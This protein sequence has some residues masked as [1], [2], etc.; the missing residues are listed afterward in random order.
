M[1]Q[2]IVEDR[3]DENLGV[4]VRLLRQRCGMSIRQ[5]AERAGVTPGIISCMERGKNSPSI[6]TLSKVLAALDSDLQAF[7]GGNGD[8][9]QGPA[10]LRE[11]M[12]SIAD[13]ERSYTIIFPKRSDIKME[14]LDEHLNPVQELP[15]LETLECDVAGYVIS[16]QL[17]LELP[18]EPPSTLR[19]GDAFYVPRGTEHRGYAWG[20][21]PAHLITVCYPAR[22]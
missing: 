13:Q 10:Y 15:P 2:A 5:L 16:G 17:R 1:S 11:H 21:T 22:Y 19:P 20:E 9:P 3:I 6:S 7:F 14:M 4:R 12:K 18:N 8:A